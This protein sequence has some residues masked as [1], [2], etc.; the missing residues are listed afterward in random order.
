MHL[1]PWSTYSKI[2]NKQTAMSP[3]GAH[4][5]TQFTCFIAGK[6]WIKPLNQSDD[7]KYRDCSC[8]NLLCWRRIQTGIPHSLKTQVLW[9]LL[10][11]VRYQGV[12]Y[13]SK[14]HG[15]C[16]NEQA[17]A[18]TQMPEFKPR[19]E[20]LKKLFRIA[21]L[22]ISIRYLP[23]NQECSVHAAEGSM[24]ASTIG[25]GKIHFTS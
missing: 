18:L 8:I 1:L 10:E 7:V 3:Q 4:A 17:V 23:L 14:T 6:L 25:A 24:L 21:S 13:L 16:R 5:P 20:T 22:D 12:H 9:H 15:K 19:N 11:G 2:C